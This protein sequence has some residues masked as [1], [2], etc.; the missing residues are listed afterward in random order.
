LHMNP[1]YWGDDAAEFKPERFIDTESY[2]WPRNAYLPFSG[3]ARSCIGQRFALAET[4]GILASVVRRYQIR[5]P[6]DLVKKPFEEQK[7]ILLEWTTGIT[8]TPLNA[9][10][11]LCRR[12]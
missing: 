8:L 7:E 5:V 1:L 3:G 2:Q 10:V 6:D 11:K 4:V 9:R 12:V